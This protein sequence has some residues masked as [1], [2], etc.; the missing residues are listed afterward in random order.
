V[1]GELPLELR[2]KRE[3]IAEINARIF[4]LAERRQRIEQA[5]LDE[6]ATFLG[7]E[8]AALLDS[9]LA[10]EKSP[11]DTCVFQ[12]EVKTDNLACLFC[13]KPINR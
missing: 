2:L 7:R 13:G 5:Y 3:R 10:C 6:L 12:V 8:G 1:S 4:A 11:V 9:H